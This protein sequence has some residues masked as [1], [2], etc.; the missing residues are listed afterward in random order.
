MRAFDELSTCWNFNS[1]IP[2]SDIIAYADRAGLDDNLADVL[3]AAVRA[4][5]VVFQKWSE[6]RRKASSGT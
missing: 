1:V 2:Y 3:I 5:D 6:R 4:M